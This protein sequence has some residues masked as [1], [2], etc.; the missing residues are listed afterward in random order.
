VGESTAEVRHDIEATREQMS[1][2]IDAIADRTSPRRIVS[3]R[4][5]RMSERMHSIRES[6]MGSP[7]DASG[8]SAA[9]GAAR[10]VQ[11]GAGAVVD[12]V[13]HAPEQLRR[14]TQGNPLA[15]G[16]IAFGGG[17]LAAAV[18]PS[19]RTERQVASR[20]QEEAQPA[21]DQLK[22]AGQQ[23]ADEVKTSAQ[24]AAQDVKES[25]SESAQRVVDEA[26]SER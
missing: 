8:Q 18:I 7:E 4:G 24:H 16:L 3:R 13:R 1:G 2:T 17:M 21:I 10:S 14:Q 26:R 19:S 20:L 6:V 11:Q 9:R 12:E 25:A 23:V 22:Q 5:R 15:A